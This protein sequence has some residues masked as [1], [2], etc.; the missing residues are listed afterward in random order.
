MSCTDATCPRAQGLVNKDDDG[1]AVKAEAAEPVPVMR[2]ADLA[3]AAQTVERMVNQNTFADIA[4]DFSFWEDP[5]D[6][7]KPRVGTLLPLWRFTNERARRKS[8]TAVAW[9]SKARTRSRLCPCLFDS[10][11]R[12]ADAP[13]ALYLPA[14]RGRRGNYPSTLDASAAHPRSGNGGALRAHVQHD[15]VFAVAYGSFDYTR[16]TSGLVC[17]FALANPTYPEVAFTTDAGAL[18]LS[19]HPQ[20]ASLLALGLYD[21]TVAVCDAARPAAKGG[22]ILCRSSIASEGHSEPVWQVAWDASDAS[23]ALLMYSVSA[24]GRVLLWT[25]SKST[26]EP[27]IAMRLRA[28]HDPAETRPLT[29]AGLCIDFNQA[30]GS[31]V[32]RLRT[33]RSR[34]AARPPRERP[35]ALACTSALGHFGTA[36]CRPLCAA[37]G[38]RLPRRHG[39]RRDPQ[40]QQGVLE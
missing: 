8:V 29:A 32:L 28:S 20:H 30:R 21:G 40:V 16:P 11:T 26:L 27:E 18:T 14:V 35:L 19:F 4:M 22:P 9:S 13:A 37:H 31:S 15:D 39:G 6:A 3:L 23:K 12:F 24:D 5:S 1:G 34:V 17:V 38:Q 10:V 2:S 36:A 7:Y 33:P 25:V